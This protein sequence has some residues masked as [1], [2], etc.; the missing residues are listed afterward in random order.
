MLIRLRKKMFHSLGVK[1]YQRKCIDVVSDKRLRK[2]K[3]MVLF[4]LK[5]NNKIKIFLLLHI[6]FAIH[7]VPQ[8]MKILLTRF[9]KFLCQ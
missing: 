9:F 6:N 5:C 2:L 8:I 4:L 3:K 7:P 1:F